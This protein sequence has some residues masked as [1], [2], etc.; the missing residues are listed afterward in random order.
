MKVGDLVKLKRP[1][2]WDPVLIIEAWHGAIKVL[3]PDGKI[4]SELAENWEVISNA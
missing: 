2:T 3:M 4:K 1:G